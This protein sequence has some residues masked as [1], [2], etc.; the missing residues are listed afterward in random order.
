M[1]AAQL[2]T[3][4]TKKTRNKSGPVQHLLL[5]RHGQT[6]AN[7][8]GIVQGHSHWL[9]NELGHRQAALVAERL[10]EF[11]PKIDILVCSDLLRAQQTAGPIATA[12]GG[13][14]VHSDRAWRE[15]CYG[16]FEGLSPEAR[17]DRIAV[18]G[19]RETDVPPGAQTVAEYQQ[20]IRD[21]FLAV[22]RQ[23][24]DAHCIA[25]VTHG[26]ACKSVL[27]MLADGRLPAT[28]KV[29]VDAKYT[30]NCSITHLTLRHAERAFRLELLHC[31]EHLSSIE[32]T[33]TDAG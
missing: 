23:F 33:A 19:L 24:P 8:L 29:A 4:P 5:I 15:R 16:E 32:A 28:H 3:D 7:R 11:T 21:A 13:L 17:A 6:D 22:P 9:L 20:Q 2:L 27:A 12:L 18:L 14:P 31:T 26:G 25:I 30:P 10:A 1:V